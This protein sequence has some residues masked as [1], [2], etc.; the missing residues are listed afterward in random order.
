MEQHPTHGA[1]GTMTA[2]AKQQQQRHGWQLEEKM[3]GFCFLN[4]SN[5]T[6]TATAKWQH[7]QQRHGWQLEEKKDAWLLLFEWKQFDFMSR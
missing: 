5:L 7:W 2:T 3:H 1:Y 6:M 4:V